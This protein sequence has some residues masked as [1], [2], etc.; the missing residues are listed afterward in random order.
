MVPQISYSMRYNQSISLWLWSCCLKFGMLC[1]KVMFLWDDN[2][3]NLTVYYQGYKFGQ[4]ICTLFHFLAQ[5]V[6]TTSETELDY[7]HQKVNARV[8]ARLKTEDLRKLGSFKKIPEMFG[9]NSEYP[10]VHPKVKFWGFLLKKCK[11]SAVKHSIEKPTLLN[12]VNFSLTFVQDCTTEKVELTGWV[13]RNLKKGPKVI[14]YLHLNFLAT[15]CKR[16]TFY[17]YLLRFHS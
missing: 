6:F 17:D 1:Q 9:F 12:F 4:N 16:F 3:Y 8:A 14:K 7:Y 5:F 11:K 15:F 13:L 2:R 10:A